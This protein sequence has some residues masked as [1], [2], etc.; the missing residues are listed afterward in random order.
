MIAILTTLSL[1]TLT[2]LDIASGILGLL[3]IIG[4]FVYLWGTGKKRYVLCM[5]S[6]I[7]FFTLMG[8]IEDLQIVE[9]SFTAKFGQY[10]TDGNDT[11]KGT[12]MLGFGNK[13]SIFTPSLCE[14]T[15]GEKEVLQIDTGVTMPTYQSDQ[16]CEKYLTTITCNDLSFKDCVSKIKDNF[17][18]I[19]DL[20]KK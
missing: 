19:K 10:T 18:K 12:L 8:F 16:P 15:S 2:Y 1:S 7:L 14:N 6:S 3:L 11:Q 20:A 17:E 13:I 4:S 5:F 9:S